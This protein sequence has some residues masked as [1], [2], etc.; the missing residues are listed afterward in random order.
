MKRSYFADN[1]WKCNCGA[2]NSESRKG[3]GKCGKEKKE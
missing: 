2:L 1:A 3:C